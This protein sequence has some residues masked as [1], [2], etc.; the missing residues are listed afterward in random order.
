[1]LIEVVLFNYDRRSEKECCRK[2]E[3][4]VLRRDEIMIK[5]GGVCVGAGEL[6]SVLLSI[7]FLEII[8]NNNN[9]P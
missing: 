3:G 1:M 6:S 4:V 8:P 7:V 2:V 5:R 9:N